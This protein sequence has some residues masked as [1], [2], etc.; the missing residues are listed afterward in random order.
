MKNALFRIVR[1]FISET[2]PTIRRNIFRLEEIFK[3]KLSKK[4]SANATLS[5]FLLAS[6]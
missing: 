5:S 1:P 2:F 3:Q 4:L 6:A